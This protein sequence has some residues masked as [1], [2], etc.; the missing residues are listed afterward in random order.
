MG[1]DR[2]KALAKARHKERKRMA[3]KCMGKVHYSFAEA[4]IEGVRYRQKPYKCP[5]C[6]GWCLTGK[7]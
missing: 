4:Q 6:G 7:R 1:G 5:I 3:G 2:R